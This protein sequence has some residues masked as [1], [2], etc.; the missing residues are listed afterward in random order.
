MAGILGGGVQGGEVVRD[1]GVGVEGVHGVEVAHEGRALLGQVRGAAAAQDQDVDVL[2][3][4]GRVGQGQDGHA[5]RVQ[6]EALRVAAGKDRGK[7]H[8]RGVAQGEL[9][10]AAQVAIPGDADSQC[11]HRNQPP[12]ERWFPPL[13]YHTPAQS[14]SGANI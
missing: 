1:V 14:K 5:G 11:F 10:A 2:G 8:V 13:V 4:G 3:M 9:H 7:F 12:K 6:G